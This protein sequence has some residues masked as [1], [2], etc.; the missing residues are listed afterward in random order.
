MCGKDKI[1]VLDFYSYVY[2]ASPDV[3]QRTKNRESNQDNM[4]Y[5]IEIRNRKV[6]KRLKDI[7]DIPKKLPQVNVW[8]Y[9]QE[10]NSIPFKFSYV[11]KQLEG[12]FDLTL[13]NDINILKYL[14]GEI[15]IRK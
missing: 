6:Y 4:K 15:P 3:N 10:N 12:D 9:P 13:L 7:N 1:G 5:E 2:N 14:K 11:Y 8:D